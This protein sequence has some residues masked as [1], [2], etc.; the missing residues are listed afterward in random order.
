MPQLILEHSANIFEKQNLTKLFQ[1]LH[2]LLTENLPTQL[3]NCKSRAIEYT[4]YYVGDG[5]P[6]HAFV[7]INLKVLPGRDFATLQNTGEK[8][9][10]E[11]KN[12]FTESAQ[13]LNLQISLE[14]S[15]LEKIYF[16]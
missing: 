14:I 12:Y 13:K 4:T 15:E 5:N 6:N 16:K 7:H 3:A 2:Q 9:M 1:T 11:S 8:I 10:E